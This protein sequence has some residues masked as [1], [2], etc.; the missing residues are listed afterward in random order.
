MTN[1]VRN[2]AGRRRR[3]APLPVG[4][5]RIVAAGGES[6]TQPDGPSRPMNARGSA[7][8]PRSP[9]VVIVQRQSPNIVVRLIW[10]VCAGWW[11]TGL[12]SLLAW[13][14]A[15]T[16]IG[17]P[18]SISLLNRIPQVATLRMSTPEAIALVDGT[19]AIQH[20]RQRAF[21][22]RAVYYLL[23]GWWFTAIWLTLAW[24]LVLSIIGI[25]LAFVM[26]G[27]VG[28]VLTLKR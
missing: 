21:W 19:V 15:A 5:V 9:T 3:D 10:F 22:V 2:R 16:I 6:M 17:I 13:A 4:I 7:P 27:A 14:L 25:P 1:A 20:R 26:Y 24:T 18:L 28:S 23:I 11:L 8:A 12:V